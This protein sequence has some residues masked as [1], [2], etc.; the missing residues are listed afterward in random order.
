MFLIILIFLLGD[1]S[2]QHKGL[3]LTSASK[4]IFIIKTT[5][6]TEIYDELRT[7]L[8][9]KIVKSKSTCLRAANHQNI[10][11]DYAP[12]PVHLNT[13]LGKYSALDANQRSHAK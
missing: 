8:K 6:V 2:D 13:I 12:P 7:G 4:N 5:M 9:S 1:V 3:S 11:M 10:V